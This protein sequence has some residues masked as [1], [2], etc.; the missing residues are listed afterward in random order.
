MLANTY[1][2]NTQK[3]EAGGSLVQGQV[4]LLGKIL[5][6]SKAKQKTNRIENIPEGRQVKSCLKIF[7]M[8]SAY[9]KYKGRSF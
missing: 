1:I 8:T 9:G 4:Q 2:L 3:A 5:S 7:N 6:F